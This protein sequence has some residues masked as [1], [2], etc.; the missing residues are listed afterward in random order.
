[1]VSFHLFY[2]GP[3]H[4]LLEKKMI[5]VP[6]AFINPFFLKFNEHISLLHEKFFACMRTRKRNVTLLNT[7]RGNMKQLEN[8]KPKICNWNF[9]IHIWG[10]W[11]GSFVN[12]ESSLFFFKRISKKFKMP[13]CKVDREKSTLIYSPNIRTILT[14]GLFFCFICFWHFSCYLSFHFELHRSSWQT[15]SNGNR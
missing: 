5:F 2:S 3:K 12:S 15:L 4:R 6:V 7:V 13:L 14:F 11:N 9:N 1:M 10:N 8:S